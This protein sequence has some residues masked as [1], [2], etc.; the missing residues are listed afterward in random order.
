MVNHGLSTGG[1]FALV[2][3]IYERWH[4]RQIDDLS[5]LARVTPKLAALF[6]LF[7]LSS[8]GLP[9]LNGFA[10]EFL[11]LL[12]MFQRAFTGVDASWALVYRILAVLAVCGV[13]LGAWYMLWLVQRVFFGP[14][15]APSHAP[16][17]PPVRDLSAREAAALAPLVLLMF[18]IGLAPQF[19]LERTANALDDVTAAAAAQLS[20]NQF[21]RGPTLPLGESRR[22]GALARSPS[23]PSPPGEEVNLQILSPFND[24]SAVPITHLPN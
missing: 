22:E 14:L 17:Q 19:F 3:M 2:G 7:T 12:G 23:V 24:R 8:I 5:G 6:V 21:V 9:G 10:G 4:T 18:W 16:D 1:L 20:H 15:K 13:V 11:I